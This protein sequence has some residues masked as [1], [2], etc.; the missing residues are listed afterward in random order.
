M[1]IILTIVLMTIVLITIVV[2]IIVIITILILTIF[3]ITIV[4]KTIV[5]ITIFNNY[6]R[7]GISSY[8]YCSND[9]CSMNHEPNDKLSNFYGSND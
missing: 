7:V 3:I 5:L 1:F 4:I 8:G 9:N 6:C 2:K